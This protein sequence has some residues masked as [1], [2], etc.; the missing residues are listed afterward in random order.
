MMINLRLHTGCELGEDDLSVRFDH[1]SFSSKNSQ[2]FDRQV[3]QG[4]DK[5]KQ[6]SCSRRF[7]A[8]KHGRLACSLASPWVL[9][10]S[11]MRGIDDI[12]SSFL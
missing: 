6:S 2:G 10:S 4:D 8:W 12:L 1:R 9:R 11:H 5:K 7:P 3:Q